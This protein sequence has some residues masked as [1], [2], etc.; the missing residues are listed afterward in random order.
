MKHVFRI[1]V[2]MMLLLL[3]TLTQALDIRPYTATA[4][5]AAQQSGKPVALHFHADWCPTCRAQEKSFRSLQSDKGLD[6]TLFVVN[7][8]KERALRKQLGVRVQ[9]T[10]IVYRGY[11]ETIRSGGETRPEKLRA[12]LATAL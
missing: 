7:Y 1:T 12:V 9:S 5:K 8:D 2:A 6:L 11:R 10:V 4:F 3:S